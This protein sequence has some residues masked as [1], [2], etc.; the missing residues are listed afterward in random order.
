MPWLKKAAEAPTT[1]KIWELSNELYRLYDASLH[2]CAKEL[3][4]GHVPA[5]RIS[6]LTP[7]PA[8]KPQVEAL[9]VRRLWHRLPHLTCKSCLKLRIDH[10]TGEL[11]KSGYLV[12]DFLEFNPSKAEWQSRSEK[13]AEAGRFGGVAKATN[14]DVF[15]QGLVDEVGGRCPRCGRVKPLTRDHVLP[16]HMGG[17]DAPENIQPMCRECNSAKGKET[18]NWL[19]RWR[20]GWRPASYEPS[21]AASSSDSTM[22]DRVSGTEPSGAPSPYSVPRT[23][24]SGS[25][26]PVS[27]DDDPFPED[28]QGADRSRDRVRR[29]GVRHVGAAAERV[30][31]AARGRAAS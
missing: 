4:D 20:T 2:Y 8:T 19:V 23:P 16:V 18:T 17:T 22:P 30:V 27:G 28:Q 29:G 21:T 5:S 13:R 1:D 3:T 10:D 9:V 6:A 14:R 7:K 26:D 25:I 24:S 11:P 12:H 15:F 31:A